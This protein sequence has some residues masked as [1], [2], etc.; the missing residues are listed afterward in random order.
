MQDHVLRTVGWRRPS[1]T[2]AVR[3]ELL[4]GSESTGLRTVAR[5]LPV[6]AQAGVAGMRPPHP[7]QRSPRTVDALLVAVPEQVVRCAAPPSRTASSD[8]VSG[9]GRTTWT[10]ARS[11]ST[12]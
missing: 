3:G 2:H 8:R 11:R 10:A 5:L 9:P 4:G 6:R 1:P 12:R 7:G